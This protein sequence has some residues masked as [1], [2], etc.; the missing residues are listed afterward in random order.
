MRLAE[1][2]QNTSNEVAKK[3]AMVAKKVGEQTTTREHRLGFTT[4]FAT[5]NATLGPE[6]RAQTVWS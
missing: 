4:S 6:N 5:T 2:F 1:K 3:V